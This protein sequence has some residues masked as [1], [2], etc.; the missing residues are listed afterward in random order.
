LESPGIDVAGAGPA[1]RA[2][3]GSVP[4]RTSPLDF[5][6][7]LRHALAR[8]PYAV[9]ALIA[10]ALALVA[11][12]RGEFPVNDDWAYA[13]SVQWLLG[14][15]RIRLSDWVAMNLLP[16]TLA[17]GFVTLVGGFSFERLRHLT[18]FVSVAVAMLALAWFRVAGLRRT[19][20]LVATLTLVA[21]PCW[22]PLADS[23]MTDLYAMLFALPAATLFLRALRERTPRPI[24]WATLFAALGLL[25]R[26]VVLV[27][28]VAFG[29]A[30]LAASL[31]QPRSTYRLSRIARD[32]AIAT[33]PT[34]AVVAVGFGYY[35]Y[36]AHGPGVPTA[37]QLL[38]GRVL[39]AIVKTIVNDGGF[40]RY[41]VV[42]NL[43]AIVGYVGLFAAPFAL[44][45]GESSRKWVREGIL[46][47]T[48]LAVLLMAIT[49][50]WPPWRADQLVDAAGIGP[51]TLYDAQ[52][53]GLAPLDRSAG[54]FW[55]CVGVLAAFGF[56]ALCRTALVAARAIVARRHDA[57]QV[58]FLITLVAAYLAPFVLTDF[59]DRYCVFVLPFV[60]ALIGI[61]EPAA[62]SSLRRR[63][64]MLM[65]VVAFAVEAAATHD[66]F[67]WNRARWDAIRD[68]EAR[69]ATAS[70]LDGGFEYNGYYGFET[71][72]RTPRPGKSWWWVDDDRFAVAFGAV[73]G[74]V[75]I[76]RYPVRALLP[77][78]PREVLLL[79][80]APAATT[81]ERYADPARTGP[82]ATLRRSP[83]A[84]R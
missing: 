69:G 28:P 84:A 83:M 20:S 24:A 17:G 50:F 77:R 65:L 56:A 68:A 9:V 30:W 10:L 71:K 29:V 82:S 43:F 23:F 81:P 21:A 67:A 13:H 40:Y 49:G 52:P 39:P 37:Q 18:Q 75:A 26:Q 78:T 62:S 48:A 32:L 79:E 58:V 76:A 3:V 1:A 51:F 27:V 35:T 4:R 34:L 63:T 72:P 59:I 8:H 33:L 6:A 57:P 14:E 7:A 36:L 42:S 74:Y 44:W 64:A 46:V 73:P 25:Q 2:G 45:R 16:Q 66:Y 47:V 31:S 15:H 70:T 5:A 11:D 61:V 55:I 54:A 22:L 41:W 12:P 19:A 60:L 80:R 53:R 38:Q